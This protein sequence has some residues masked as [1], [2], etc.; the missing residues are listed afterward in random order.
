MSLNITK[1][2]V[3]R[4]AKINTGNYENTDVSVE[5][6]ASVGVTDN[7]VEV[8]VERALMDMTDEML[9]EKIDAVELGDRRAKSKA[10]RFVGAR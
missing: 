5:L 10:N 6:E 8:E 3:R 4:A 9:A 2:A 7:V 1:V